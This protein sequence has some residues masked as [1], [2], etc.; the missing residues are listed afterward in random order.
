VKD[1]ADDGAECKVVAAVEFVECLGALVLD[2]GH[3][4]FVGAFLNGGQQ[5]GVRI[6]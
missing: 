2:R 3:E 1:P 6:E 4:F 5:L